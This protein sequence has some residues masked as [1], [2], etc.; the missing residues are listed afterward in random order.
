LPDPEEVEMTRKSAA[1]WL[2]RSAHVRLHEAENRAFQNVVERL[3]TTRSKL[4]RKIIRELIGQGPDLLD[5][6]WQALENLI[7][8]L[9][10]L[11]RNLNQYVKAIHTRQAK[12]S[13]L[14]LA[15]IEQVR[16]EVKRVDIWVIA[17]IARSKQR[18]VKSDDAI[19]AFRSSLC[20]LQADQTTSALREGTTT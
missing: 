13:P 10:A 11:G 16:D 18:W 2:N 8:Q 4:L 15:L 7:Y 12:A 1:E 14:D 19:S 6:E 5:H 20:P 17:I 9:G 3:Q